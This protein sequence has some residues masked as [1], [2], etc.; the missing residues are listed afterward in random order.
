MKKLYPMTTEEMNI[1]TKCE[2]KAFEVLNSFGL[3]VEKVPLRI[4]KSTH[5][6]AECNGLKYI[7]FSRQYIE[8]C[9][10]RNKMKSLV[11]TMIHEYL[12]MY[13]HQKDE[14]CGHT[15]LWKQ[16]A[17]TIT[18]K[19]EYKITRCS[20]FIINKKERENNVKYIVKCECGWTRPYTRKCKAFNYI[21]W[22]NQTNS[23]NVRYCC[24]RCRSFQLRAY[25]YE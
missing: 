8:A 18:S 21:L 11:T 25:W 9:V 1:L 2:E 7:S 24:P 14:W 6:Y 15:G 3:I 16:L 23:P 4:H 19:S 5:T 20:D 13:C 10:E 12:H 17:R 22:T